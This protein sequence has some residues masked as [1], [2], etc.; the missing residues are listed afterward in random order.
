[1]KHSRRE[2]LPA[3]RRRSTTAERWTDSTRSRS[4]TIPE[5]L[6]VSVCESGR[7]P[8]V[9]ESR[10][11]I[12][13]RRSH[14]LDARQWELHRASGPHRRRDADQR[15]PGAHRL[16]IATAVGMRRSVGHDDGAHHDKTRVP[17]DRRP[18]PV[19]WIQNAPR[20]A[21]RQKR[22]VGNTTCRR[23]AAAST[24]TS[25]TRSTRFTRFATAPNGRRTSLQRR[26]CSPTFR[27][28]SFRR[29][30]GFARI[31]RTPTIPGSHPDAGPSW[32]AQVVNAIGQSQYWNTTAIVVVWDD[33]GGLYDHVAPQQI[34]YQGLGIRVPMLI[35]SP[36]AK[37]G[38]VSHTQYEFGSLVK[39][40]EATWSLGSLGT[41]DGRANS[42]ND[43]F[44]FQQN[45]RPFSPIP[46]KL[47]ALVFP[48]PA[49][50]EPLPRRRLSR[51]RRP[52]RPRAGRGLF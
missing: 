38:Y 8:T 6:R 51:R 46:A 23:S 52:A 1:M 50:L 25:G 12:R 11:A 32:V 43:S 19:S 41:T 39:F 10:Q 34:D 47:F 2:R 18:V 5:R 4:R 30:R 16:S 29:S 28:A 44:N 17:S 37:K 26:T 14:L 49:S 36:Y 42:I 35:V 31:L 45:P 27:T 22:D 3:I 21:R 24:E 15:D 13:A 48:A 9:L 33:W 20:L 40:V 7:R